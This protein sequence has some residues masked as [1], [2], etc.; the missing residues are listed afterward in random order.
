MIL[1]CVM[2]LPLCVCTCE[3][4]LFLTSFELRLNPHCISRKIRNSSAW[5]NN[6]C[7]Q[8]LS[9]PRTDASSNCCDSL[10]V[11]VLSSANSSSRWS[12]SILAYRCT[13]ER[14]GNPTPPNKHKGRMNAGSS[15][16]L[17]L[18]FLLLFSAL[19][20]VNH[21]QFRIPPVM[22]GKG[23]EQEGFDS[24]PEPCMLPWTPCCFISCFSMLVDRG[25]RRNTSTAKAKNQCPYSEHTN[26]L[27]IVLI[28]PHMNN[29]SCLTA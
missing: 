5:E 13:S 8:M 7:G 3:C 11:Q 19:S 21:Q 23:N 2:C 12:S 10:Q 25:C 4:L 15:P 24:A 22:R 16:G 29:K 27:L 14:A 26:A 1:S 20:R 28:S 6:A 18:F 9:S 17:S